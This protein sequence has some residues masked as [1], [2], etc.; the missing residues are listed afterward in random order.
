MRGQVLAYVVAN[1]SHKDV[2]NVGSEYNDWIIPVLSWCSVLLAEETV[3]PILNIT[4]YA[5]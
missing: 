5:V 3:V 2:A 1:S 4:G